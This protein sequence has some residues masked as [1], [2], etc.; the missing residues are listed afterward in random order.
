MT[1]LYNPSALQRI[2]LKFQSFGSGKITLDNLQFNGPDPS[3][4]P[5]PGT[6]ALASCGAVAL[7]AM[8]RRRQRRK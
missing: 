3:P 6:L 5:E 4:V 2:A 1:G 7:V 8:R